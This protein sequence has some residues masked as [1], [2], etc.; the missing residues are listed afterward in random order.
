MVPVTDGQKQCGDCSLCCKLMDIKELNKPKD[1][2]CPNFQTG[3]GCGIYS[4]RPP[5]CRNFVCHWLADATIGPEWKPNHCKMML[6]MRPNILTVHVDPSAGQP[7]RAEPYRSTLR[8]WAERGLASGILVMVLKRRHAIAIHPDREEEL[9][10]MGPGT[11][12]SVSRVMTAS[13][14]QLQARIMGPQEVSARNRPT[15]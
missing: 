14:P 1:V 13:G 2:W 10:E 8:N 7:W 5:S 9:G 11:R 15:Q 3:V 12:I 4:D 6:Y